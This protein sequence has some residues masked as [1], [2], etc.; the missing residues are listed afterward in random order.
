MCLSVQQSNNFA[1]VWPF[2]YILIC[3][4][5]ILNKSQGTLMD[6]FKTKFLGV[7]TS[8]SKQSIWKIF[9]IWQ[10][11]NKSFLKLHC[12]V[13]FPAAVVPRV[14]GGCSHQQ[15]QQWH[16]ASPGPEGAFRQSRH[17]LLKH[18]WKGNSC[19]GSVSGHTQRHESSLS[20]LI[21]HMQHQ[22][23]YIKKKL[24]QV[25]VLWFI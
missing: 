3:N 21:L 11:L 18:N 23:I 9:N 2:A 19:T 5:Y 17:K 7:V 20:R 24:Y 14:G 12:P 15:P 22:S 25:T 4:I 10:Q 8:S 1:D 13:F 6:S 16:Q